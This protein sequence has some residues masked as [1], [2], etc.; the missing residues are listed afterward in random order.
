[1]K[2]IET[3]YDDPPPFSEDRAPFGFWHFF[4][5][6]ALSAS[7]WALLLFIIEMTGCK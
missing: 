7:C 4:A 5:I 6:M 1:M 2:R 3:A